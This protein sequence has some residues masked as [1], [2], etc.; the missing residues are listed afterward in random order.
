MTEQQLARLEYAKSAKGFRPE[1][2]IHPTAIIHKT[3]VIGMDGF[4]FAR[5]HDGTYVKMPHSGNVVIEK[6]V[7]IRAYV[8][9]DRAVEGSTVIGEGNKIDHHVHFA[10]NCKIG[11]YNTF[12]NGCSIE[13]SCEIGS[14][15]TFGS[16]VTVQRK[17]KIGNRC[18]FGSG[19]V[20]VK[21]VPDGSI[22]V[23]NPGRVIR[24]Q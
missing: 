23:G 13:G 24:T 18:R 17:V 11:E 21:D 20:V 16:N 4:G 3:A 12:A 7:E 9:V 1:D 8:T 15:N 22:V 2:V 5:D 10:H 6:G 19:T 14:Y